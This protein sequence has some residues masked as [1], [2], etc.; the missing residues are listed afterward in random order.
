[1]K[2]YYVYIMTSRSG[3]LYVGVTSDLLRRV[4]EHKTKA[5]PGFTAKYNINRLVHFESTDDVQEALAREKQIKGWRRS[6][7][8]ALIKSDNPKWQDL[9][10]DWYD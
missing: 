5:F 2:E 10:E 3:T 7:K 1:M 6:K 4:H 9:A 8:L